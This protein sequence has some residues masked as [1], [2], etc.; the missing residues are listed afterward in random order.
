M[1][2]QMTEG[3]CC[4]FQSVSKFVTFESPQALRAS[5]LPKKKFLMLQPSRS[6]RL[7]PPAGGSVFFGNL[8]QICNIFGPTE[9]SAPTEVVLITNCPRCFT[10]PRPSAGLLS[11]APA[12]R[13]TRRKRCRR[14][15]DR[16]RVFLNGEQSWSLWAKANSK[17]SV[18]PVVV[19]PGIDHDGNIALPIKEDVRHP[20][21]DAGNILVDPAGIRRLEDLLAPVHP[22]HFLLLKFR[23]FP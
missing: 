17:L 1:R 11:P 10:G 9:S 23:C 15:R 4:R 7:C 19:I 5:A 14:R 3:M 8:R 20:L 21:P 18:Q 2:Q 12:C 16:G 6:G 13:R 22:A